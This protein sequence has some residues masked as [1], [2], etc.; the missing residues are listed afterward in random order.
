[1]NLNSKRLA[2]Q[3][4]FEEL[5]GCTN[6]ADIKSYQDKASGVKLTPSQASKFQTLCEADCKHFLF[7]G[8][9]SLLSGVAELSNGRHTWPIVQFY[10]STYYLLRAE[11]LM[12]KRC[13]LRAN[14]VFT[15]L[16]RNGEH[17][18]KVNNKGQKSDHALTVLFAVKYLEGYDTLL[19][20]SIDD[21]ISYDWLMQQREWYQYKQRSYIEIEGNSPFFPFEDM[22]LLGQVNL[23]LSD[24]DP[25]FCFDKDYAALALP[26]KRFQLTI[27][28]AEEKSIRLGSNAIKILQDFGTSNESCAR[29]LSLLR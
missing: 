21:Q 26:V 27:A 11:L 24:P 25:Y 15:V 18:E 6:L 12:R 3:T 29:L 17:I 22:E 23:F 1:M 20:Q 19:T 9:L 2:T 7:K 4:Y 5:L 13:I 28:N 14:R 8:A 10:Y 16:C